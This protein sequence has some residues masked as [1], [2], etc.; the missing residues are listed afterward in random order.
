LK[1]LLVVHGLPIGGTEVMVCH[2]AR[3][4]RDSNVEVEL[5]CLDQVG[6]LG[7]ELR[8]EGFP[9][10]LYGRRP[11]WDL[12][13]PRRIG[14]HVRSGGFEV[15]HAHQYTC[16]LYGALAGL[17]ARTPLVFTEH[18]RFFPDVPS[19]KRR[20][21]NRLFGGTARCITAVSQG[22]KESLVRVEGFRPEN[23][24]VLYNGIDVERFAAAGR[25]SREELRRRAGLPVD[26]TIVGTVGRLDSIKNQSL[27]LHS[28]ARLSTHQADLNLV[29]VGDGP[30]RN[31]LEKEAEQ[32]GIGDRV[33]FL[34]NRSDTPEL[35]AAFDVFALSSLSEGTPMTLLEAMAAGT[36]IVSTAVGGIPEILTTD[37]DSILVDGVPPD[38]R[39]RP[40]ADADDYL[41]RFTSS[42]RLLL[43]DADIRERLTASA[44][45]RVVREFSLAV[46]CERYI[47]LYESLRGRE[48]AREKTVVGG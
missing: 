29:I 28:V 5:G 30:E 4:L 32:L 13:L 46:I 24:D 38:Y 48:H 37:E 41:K 45:R 27:L 44:R 3:Y 20:I 17:F 18:G 33:D 6:E 8:E 16:F 23:V 14:R 43:S 26:A 10:T 15:V 19:W 7:K 11:G 12:G 39:T 36:P 9:I 25:R 35:I 47:K 42:L 40:A 22:V 34:G 21:F 1:V 31:R 2:L